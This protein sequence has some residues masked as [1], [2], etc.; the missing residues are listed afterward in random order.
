MTEDEAKKRWCPAAREDTGGIGPV[1]GNRSQSSSAYTMC[2]ASEC[3]WWRWEWESKQTF[4]TTEQPQIFEQS[5]T[6]GHC[7]MAGKP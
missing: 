5:K 7:G 1:A 3:M 6:H 2:I 4:A